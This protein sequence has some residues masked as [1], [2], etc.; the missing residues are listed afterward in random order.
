MSTT[1]RRGVHILPPKKFFDFFLV[2]EHDTNH[3]VEPANKL[4]SAFSASVT[5]ERYG[6]ASRASRWR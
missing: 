3:L 1:S 2:V 4:A 6:A 5:S